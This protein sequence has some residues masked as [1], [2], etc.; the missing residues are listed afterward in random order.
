VPEPSTA[1]LFISGVVA[2]GFGYGWRRQRGA[3]G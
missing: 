2:C 1:V 3:V